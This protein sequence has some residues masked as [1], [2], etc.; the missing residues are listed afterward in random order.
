MTLNETTLKAIANEAKTRTDSKRW[1]A[2]IDKA[3]SG[4]LGG[5]IVTELFD[6]I[7][8]T[9]ENG[10]YHANGVCQ[11]KAFDNGTACKHRAAARLIAIY[12]EVATPATSQVVATNSD[13]PATSRADV[14]AE[15]KS[16]WPKS[17]PPLAV[18][19]MARF[20]KNNLEMLA[21]DS[22]A[23]VRLAISM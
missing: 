20:G 18:E 12:N 11:C 14:I 6:G 13:K 10:T 4:L 8:V 16:I 3:V 5:W 22:L 23:A 9:T 21:D 19:L 17:W 1:H 15:I 2:A 7:M